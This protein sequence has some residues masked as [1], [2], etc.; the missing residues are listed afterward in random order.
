[1][2]HVCTDTTWLEPSTGLP[3]VLQANGPLPGSIHD[4][5]GALPIWG[6]NGEPNSATTLVKTFNLPD[7]VAVTSATARFVADDGV[8]FHVNGQEIGRFDALVWPPPTEANVDNLVPGLNTIS[9]D[10]Y[11]RPSWA[12]LEACLSV[13]Y[14]SA[15]A[16]QSAYLPVVLDVAP[17]TPQPTPMPTASPSAQPTATHTVTPTPVATATPSANLLIGNMPLPT[18]WH[19]NGPLTYWEG[20][21]RVQDEP[22]IEIRVLDCGDNSAN[23]R[24]DIL[25]VYDPD[26]KLVVDMPNCAGD[27]TISVPT[28]GK[29]GFYRLFFQDNDTR[30]GN[31]GNIWVNR[32]RDQHI[33]TDPS[34]PVLAATNVLAQ[35]EP[36]PTGWATYG[37]LTFWEGYIHIQ[38]ETAI[39][40]RATDC[41]DNE[42]DGK[43]DA[44]QITDST[45]LIVGEASGCASSSRS[46]PIDTAGKPGW[47]RIYFLDKD[48]G[49]VR[50]TLGNGGGLSVEGLVDQHVYPVPGTGPG[51]SPTPT[52]ADTWRSVGPNSATGGGISDNAGDAEIYLRR[53]DRAS[54]SALGGSASGGG[55]SDNAGDSLWPAVAVGPDGRPWVAWHDLSGGD[56][57]IFVRRWNGTAW[58]EVGGGSAAGGGIS[59]NTGASAYVDLQVAANGDAVAAW[60]DDSGGNDEIYA[61]QWNGSAW[62]ALGGSATGG[63]VS[64][65]SGRSGR[66]ALALDPTGRPAIAWTEASGGQSNIYV[67]RWNGSAWA[68]M[69]D[70]SAAGGGISQSPG[71]SQYPAL[72]FSTAGAAYL[73]WYDDAAGQREII[74]ASWDGSQ[75]TAAAPG[76]GGVSATAG[77]SKEPD[78]VLAA[79]VPYVVWQETTGADNEIYV[80]RREGTAWAEVGLNSA[81]GGGIS[82]N[83]GD[84]NFPVAAM[85]GGR[86]FVVW[87]DDSGGDFEIYVLAYD[88]GP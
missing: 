40:V 61:R 57:E 87:E 62:V 69:G 11:N 51:P 34:N 27:P 59:D 55:I 86:V 54:W 46:F 85:A 41:G 31:G 22:L 76:P 80:R 32:L 20:L 7:G 2:I 75:W 79:G 84:S 28:A 48:T 45:G 4:I 68:E 19:T 9:A 38:N 66:P 81:T 78:L 33:Y 56:A 18:G 43:L 5:Q 60:V 72:A 71:K 58:T 10:V 16:D 24:L 88:V 49:A 30:N 21:L 35:I 73:A 1:M 15:A 52:S 25:Q 14:T 23:N 63:G 47:Y 53:W 42:G 17:A 77:E 37:I 67:R 3:A 36:L 74:A 39:T 65:D 29:P 44:I 50:S 64:D 8:V 6:Q 82:D 13:E 83:A 12:W 26:G 70:G